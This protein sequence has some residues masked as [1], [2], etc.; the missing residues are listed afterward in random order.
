MSLMLAVSYATTAVR[1]R[2]PPLLQAPMRGDHIHIPLA[3]I[4]RGR[5]HK[6]V[7]T[8]GD[9]TMRFFVIRRPDDS[10][11]VALDAC[12]IC[13]PKGYYLDGDV[14]IC[15]NCDAPI[16]VDTIGQGGGCNP[17]PLRFTTDGTAV[18]IQIA[19]LLKDGLGRFAGK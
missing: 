10:L 1:G 18:D 15:R 16:N 7:Y 5:M 6:Y 3:T 12:G 11:A 17:I 13:P 2:E 19:D 8:S 9:T 14:V 4:E